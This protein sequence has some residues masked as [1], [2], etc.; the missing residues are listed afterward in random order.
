MRRFERSPGQELFIRT[1]DA[2]GN[3]PTRH[4][5]VALGRSLAHGE[6]ETEP[7]AIELETLFVSAMANLDEPQLTL[8][9]RFSWTSNQL[10]LGDSKN[11]DFDVPPHALNLTQM[12]MVLPEY[13]SVL[14]MLAA[15]LEA[16]G[17]ITGQPEGGGVVGAGIGGQYRLTDFGR[18]VL[19]RLQAV[20]SILQ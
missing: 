4:K 1:M 18:Q 19:A 6:V 2:A 7:G 14:P 9:E 17:I 10:G 16:Q 20:A 12:A 3:S 5:L 11:P 15:L 13:K 8:L